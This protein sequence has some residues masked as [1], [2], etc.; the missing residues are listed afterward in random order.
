LRQI[1]KQPQ[2]QPLSVAEQVATV[3][4]GLNG[5]IDE[6]P[7]DKATEFA[8]GLREYLGTSKPKYGEIIDSEKKLTEEAESLL[9]EGI[10]EYKET[11]MAAA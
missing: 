2:N 3:Y 5:Y 7:V 4:A 11:F 9:K 10:N 6:V 1:L 8:K